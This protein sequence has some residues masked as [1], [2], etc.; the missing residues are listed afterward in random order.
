MSQRLTISGMTFF[1]AS[2]AASD[3][4]RRVLYW[5]LTREWGLLELVTTILL[6]RMEMGAYSYSMVPQLSRMAESFLPMAEANWS[7]M[8]VLAP[9]YLFSATLP[10]LASSMLLSFASSKPLRSLSMMAVTTSREAE[11]ERPEPL[12]TSP[13]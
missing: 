8:P 5:L 9:R 12:G 13:P 3:W 1:R 2:L 11:E 6:P 10:I 7:R 4:A